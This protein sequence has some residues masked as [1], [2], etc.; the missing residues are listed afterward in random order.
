AGG[1]Y[2]GTTTLTFG[3]RANRCSRWRARSAAVGSYL[4]IHRRYSSGGVHSLR[5]RSSGG[6][7]SLALRR[8]QSHAGTVPTR[9]RASLKR[10]RRRV[11]SGKRRSS[12]L[13]ANRATRNAL[14]ERMAASSDCFCSSNPV[15][16]I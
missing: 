9:R 5:W 8:D 14:E 13:L 1:L 11:C 15:R 2:T 6:G 3:D 4:L 16:R 10:V 7:P 12:S